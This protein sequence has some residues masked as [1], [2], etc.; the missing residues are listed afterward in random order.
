MLV[1]GGFT[2]RLVTSRELWLYG[3]ESEQWTQLESA[4]S[5]WRETGE[6]RE[7]ERE[8]EREIKVTER[9]ITNFFIP[10]AHRPGWPH[11][12]PDS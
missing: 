11:C 12:Y 9:E 1:F 4:V 8:R 2:S 7:G 3:G 10:P 6:R 5:A